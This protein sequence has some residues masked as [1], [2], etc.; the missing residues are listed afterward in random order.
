MPYK[1][2]LRFSEILILLLI[3]L[4][5]ISG[6]QSISGDILFS[7][8]SSYKRER[9]DALLSNLKRENTAT[10]ESKS[11]GDEK[12]SPDG[13][14]PTQVPFIVNEYDP[15]DWELIKG[16]EQFIYHERIIRT[17]GTFW[18]VHKDVLNY[19][20]GKEWGTIQIEGFKNETLSVKDSSPDG[21][22]WLEGRGKDNSTIIQ[23]KGNKSIITDVPSGKKN[24]GLSIVS[25]RKNGAWV[26]LDEG[27]PQ[28]L[29]HFDGKNW[30]EFPLPDLDMKSGEIYTDDLGTLWLD[31]N[32]EFSRFDG[33]K[34]KIYIVDSSTRDRSNQS[35]TRI[36]LTLG[37][38]GSIWVVKGY[39]P[40]SSVFYNYLPNGKIEKINQNF[41]GI[42]VGEYMS[43]MVDKN[44]HLWLSFMGA[45]DANT[46]VIFWDGKNWNTFSNLPFKIAHTILQ[47][48]AK[49][50]IQTEKGWYFFTP[51]ES[52]QVK[53]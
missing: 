1:N 13:V 2:H 29:F 31:T 42:N 11:M 43:M 51:D 15:G 3:P 9:A 27:V 10:P 8:I 38:N 16:S 50:L 5:F 52:N 45:P 47:N 33:K 19:Y 30:K 17:N 35:E 12:T 41:L 24:T 26:L 21:S 46:P 37:T 28:K 6:C 34:W 20:D 14:Q 44:N 18:I 40:T 48:D 53:K 23:V 4:V 22:L 49:M 7:L 25:D 36:L 39:S 32:M